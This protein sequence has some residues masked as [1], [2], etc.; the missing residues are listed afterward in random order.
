MLNFSS[1][2]HFYCCS[3]LNLLIA[4]SFNFEAILRDLS[5]MLMKIEVQL[6]SSTP[7]IIVTSRLSAS[8]F[9]SLYRLH[10]KYQTGNYQR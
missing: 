1:V 10:L 7:G 9:Q 5:Y 3:F 6:L 4:G 8:P 2:A